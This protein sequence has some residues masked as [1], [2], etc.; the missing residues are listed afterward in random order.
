M[1][2]RG[3]SVTEGGFGRTWA[4]GVR[5][6][7]GSTGPGNGQSAAVS[8]AMRSRARLAPNV[9]HLDV[10][11]LSVGD[12]LVVQV[13]QILPSAAARPFRQRRSPSPR[14]TEATR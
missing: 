12:D 13:A 2:W 1:T 4:A 6:L 7:S 3:R 11:C 10:P 14:L 8:N 9:Q 5:S